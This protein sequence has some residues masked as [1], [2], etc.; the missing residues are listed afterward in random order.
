M[1]EYNTWVYYSALIVSGIVAVIM[2]SRQKEYSLIDVVSKYY[3]RDKTIYFMTFIIIG[4][5]VFW[6]AVRNGIIDTAEYIDNYINLDSKTSIFSLWGREGGRFDNK[7]P[8]FYTFQLILKKLGFSWKGYLATIAIISGI[9]IIYGI[10][11]YTDD[12]ALSGYLFVT[13]TEFFWLFNGVRQ[14]LVVAIMFAAFRLIYEKKFVVFL[15]LVAVMYFIH[16]TA[17]I[18][19]PIYFIANMKNWSFGIFICITATVIITVAFPG[20]ITALL[21]SAFSE[22]NV[23]KAFAQD[24]GANILRFLVAM[25]TP[26]LAFI[27]RNK[28]AEY[29]DA[30]INVLINISLINAGLQAVAVV[31]SGIYMGRLPIYTEIFNLVFLPFLIKKVVGQR[32]KNAILI[33]C[34]VLYF[35]FFYLQSKDGGMIYTTHLFSSMD[36]TEG[37]RV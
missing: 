25:V 13:T 33:S 24:D 21:A 35:L 1:F 22:Y 37:F 11:R 28:L 19:I 17:I 34:I 12:V 4:Y 5:I 6:A 18:F 15:I 31:T 7:A 36:L 9:F 26:T 8:L 14:M 27:Y 10:G 20:R 29:N 23:E 3:K 32:E 16:T 30:K 2:Y